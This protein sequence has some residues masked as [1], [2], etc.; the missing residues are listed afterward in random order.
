MT[1]VRVLNKEWYQEFCGVFVTVEPLFDKH[2]I[3]STPIAEL[4]CFSKYY[5]GEVNKYDKPHG[6]GILIDQFSGIIEGHFTNGVPHK[7]LKVLAI[8]ADTFYWS[9]LGCNLAYFEIGYF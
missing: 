4:T 1:N 9:S 8:T 7:Q 6:K 3:C 2:H 5:I